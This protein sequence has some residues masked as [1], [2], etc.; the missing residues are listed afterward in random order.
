MA[1]L[2]LAA[3]GVAV[4]T[5]AALSLEGQGTLAGEIPVKFTF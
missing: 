3:E 2:S 5:G 1:S 4:L